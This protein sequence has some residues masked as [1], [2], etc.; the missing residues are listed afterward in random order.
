MITLMSPAIYVALCAIF[1]LVLL[2]AENKGRDDLKRIAK[3]AASATFIIAGLAAGALETPFGQAIFAGLV[4]CALGD[5]LLIPK[6]EKT[7]L[8]G[9]G[10]F[11]AGHAAYIAAFLIGGVAFGG[12]AIVGAFAAILFSGGFL[13]WIWRDLGEFRGPVAGYSAIITLMV[14]ASIAHLAAA[15]GPQSLHLALAAAGFAISDVSVARDQFRK[16]EF[17]N[18]LWGLPLYYAAQCLFAVSV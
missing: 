2:K 17:F 6:S 14:A 18:R 7:F 13:A 12:T 1:V 16:P 5:V 15:P 9:M 8:A 11:A 10:A 4:L 3:P